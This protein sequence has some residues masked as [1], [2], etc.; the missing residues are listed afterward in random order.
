MMLQSK[1]ELQ[2]NSEHI[3]TNENSLNCQ[4]NVYYGSGLYYPEIA[5]N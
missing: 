5:G 3:L 4:P 2:I 1:S